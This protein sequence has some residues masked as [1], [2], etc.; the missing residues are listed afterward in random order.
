MKNSVIGKY[1]LKIDYACT[2]ENPSL[3]EMNEKNLELFFF[4]VSLVSSASFLSFSS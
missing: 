4:L 3:A 1:E 2:W